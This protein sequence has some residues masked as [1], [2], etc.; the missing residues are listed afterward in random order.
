MKR[1]SLLLPMFLLACAQAPQNTSPA[2]P[3]DRS[4]GTAN[5]ALLGAYHWRLSEASDAQGQPIDALFARADKP[6]QLDFRDGRLA[7]GNACNRMGGAYSASGGQL[8]LGNLVSTKMA[9]AD[10]RLMAL[11]EAVGKRLQ[12]TLTFALL[13]DAQPRLTLTDAA[14]E[15]L[16]FLGEPTADTYHG[17]PGEIVFL[18]ID[19]QAK[20]CRHPLIP[21]KRC[22]QVREIQYD[23]QGIKRAPGAWQNAYAEI[24]GY[25]HAPGIRNVLRVRRYTIKNPPADGSSLAYVLDMVVESEAVKP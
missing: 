16:V 23:G 12:G 20:P 3:A 6:L 15:R 25:T 18:E 2:A 4:T 13:A 21:D 9:C 5:P 24:Q 1:A 11:D 14:G 19:A 17:G 22:L 10:P 7:V 8:K